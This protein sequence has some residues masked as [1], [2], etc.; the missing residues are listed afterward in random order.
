MSPCIR[1]WPAFGILFLSACGGGG[2]PA[3][4]PGSSAVATVTVTLASNSVQSGSSTQAS[5]ILRD[6]GGAVLTGRA[7]S[8]ASSNTAV[9]TVGGDGQVAAIAPGATTITASSEGRSGSAQLTVAQP[10]VASVSITGTSRV[11]VGDTYTYTAQAR[12]ADGTI[13]VRPVVWS[14]VETGRATITA[15]GVLTPLV[16][17]SITVKATVESVSFGGAVTAYDWQF[18][19]SGGVVAAYLSADLAISNQFGTNEFPTLA[20]GCSSGTFIIYVD[21]ENFVT[22]N[23]LVSF[24]LDGGTIFSQTWVEFDVFSAL[25]HPGPTNLATKNL[26]AAIAAARSFAFA[27][28]EFQST[29]RATIFRVTGLNPLL[30]QVLNA[31]PSNAIR[32]EDDGVAPLD[33][34]APLLSPAPMT[35]DRVARAAMGSLESASPAAALRAAPPTPRVRLTRP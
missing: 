15:G 29:A 30:T 2:D 16:T 26:A 33:R 21:T 18:L 6:G 11:K 4:T 12:L 9:A 22:Q 35:P 34:L 28:T 25:A 31:C 13:V 14:V 10:A 1:Q 19:D 17:G 7:V 32:A 24:S 20:I 5:A 3:G 8:W 27:F 23:G